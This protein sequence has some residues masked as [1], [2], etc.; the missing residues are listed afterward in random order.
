[1]LYETDDKSWPKFTFKHCESDDLVH[2][3]KIPEALYGTDKYVGGPAL[4]FEDGWYYTLYLEDLGG[5]YYETRITR[6]RDLVDW[7]DAPENRAFLT[8]DPDRYTNPIHYPEVRELNASD[9][10]LCEWKG[11]TIIYFN[12]GDQLNCGDVQLAEFDGSPKELFAYF[13]ESK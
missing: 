4:Y 9:V 7:Q 3:R 1:M 8:F 10:E 13:F 5:G 2:W 6:S 12:G 11:K